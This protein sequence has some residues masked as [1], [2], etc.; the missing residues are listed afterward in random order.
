MGAENGKILRYFRS[1]PNTSE[2]DH[3]ESMMTTESPATVFV[4][5]PGVALKGLAELKE[6]R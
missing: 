5:P 6:D 2:G 1:R 4:T 3:L